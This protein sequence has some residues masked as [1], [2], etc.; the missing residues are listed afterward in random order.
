M[1]HQENN[2]RSLMQPLQNESVE[3]KQRNQSEEAMEVNK[4]R[5]LLGAVKKQ[6]LESYQLMADEEIKDALEN[7][8]VIYSRK[9]K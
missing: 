8:K 6:K 9:K 2:K 5:M 1:Q 3:P 4:L 7:G